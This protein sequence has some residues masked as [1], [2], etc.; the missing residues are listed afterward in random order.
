MLDF[1]CLAST[2][3]DEFIYLSVTVVDV[4]KNFHKKSKFK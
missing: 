1:L 2:V 4:F 3:T